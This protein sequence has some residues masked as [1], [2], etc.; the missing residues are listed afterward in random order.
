ML[1]EDIARSYHNQIQE[2]SSS[3]S[4]Q[5]NPDPARLV[6]LEN[7]W[8]R[9]GDAHIDIKNDKENYVIND[10][11]YDENKKFKS[12]L[13][14]PLDISDYVEQFFDISL[15]VFMS[16]TI[17]KEGFCENMGFDPKNVAYIDTPYSPFPINNRKI[18]FLNIAKLS[19]ARGTINDEL[20]VIK[21]IDELLTKH[22][23]ERGLILTSSF[24]R[25]VDIKSNLS[26][27]NKKRVRICHSMNEYGKTQ[28]EVLDEHAKSEN[29]VLLSSSLWEGVDLRD[30]LSRFQIIAKTPYPNLG[31]KRVQIKKKKFPL[32]YRSQTITKMLQGFGR[33]VRNENDWAVTYVMDST[34]R[35]LLDNWKD[36]VPLAYHD[37]LWPYNEKLKN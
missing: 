1:L 35:D 17:D 14:V 16:A 13:I 29:G 19:K 15:R 36:K 22:S 6:K 28:N 4:Y 30:E 10:P 33:S 18:E 20:N 9:F 12:I 31:D 37:V 27:L 8:K 3:R 7:K 11:L 24:S 5:N 23:N 26:A 25:C 32:W 21:K 34:A 2:L